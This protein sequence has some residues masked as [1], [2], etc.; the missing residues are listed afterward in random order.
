MNK[1]KIICIVVAI[2]IIPKAHAQ[3][4]VDYHQSSLP[5]IGVNYEIKDRFL[6]E[7]R[8]GTNNYFEDISFEGVLTY[9]IINKEDYEFYGGL[10]YR[11]NL[12]RGIVLPIGLNIYPF[13]SKNFGFHLELAPI[14]G[15]DNLLRGSWGIRYRFRKE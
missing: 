15:D 10:G 6:P 9:Q 4:G 12:Y 14:V 13:T 3:L 2:L 1:I 11:T 5:F 8:L 7:L